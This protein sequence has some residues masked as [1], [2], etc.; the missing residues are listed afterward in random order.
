[1]SSVSELAR[2][3]IEQEERLRKVIAAGQRACILG[4]QEMA[5]REL[6]HARLRVLL[7]RIEAWENVDTPTAD[8]SEELLLDIKQCLESIAEGDSL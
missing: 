3:A 7:R 4:E 8:Q 2:I 6:E 1:M 5:L